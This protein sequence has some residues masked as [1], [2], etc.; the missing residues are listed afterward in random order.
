MIYGDCSVV[1]VASRIYRWKW[2]WLLVLKVV[3][4]IFWTNCLTC[5]RKVFHNESEI[6]SA[7]STI[8]GPIL[9]A[10]LYKFCS[11]YTCDFIFK[12][13]SFENYRAYCWRRVKPWCC[14]G[15]YLPILHCILVI[16]I[17]YSRDAEPDP[18]PEQQALL[19]NDSSK[20]NCCY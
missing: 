13:G 20:Y 17:I 4:L 8:I 18:P 3:F 16:Q 2:W 1:Y 19:P 11:K 14:L 12:F 6:V 10:P 5:I 9:I 15:Y 7:Y